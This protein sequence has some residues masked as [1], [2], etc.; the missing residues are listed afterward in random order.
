MELKA[1]RGFNDILPTETGQW[2]VV[3]ERAREVLEGFGFSEIRVPILEKTE[4]FSRSIGEETDIVE[5]EMYTFQ[6]RSGDLVTLRPEATASLA[7]A[8]IEHKMYAHDPMAKLYSIGP[9]FRHERPQKGRYRQFHQVDVE[10]FGVSHPMVDAEV[11][12]ILMHYLSVL[13][14]KGCELQIT[15]LG[16][17]TCRVPYKEDL[18]AFLRDHRSQL[19]PDC[20]RR[21]EINPLRVFD[22]KVQG[23]QE[24]MS[25]APLIGNYLCQECDEH[26]AGVKAYLETLDVPYMIN[27][28]MVRGLDY[29]TKTAFEVVAEALG[30]QNAV[31]GGGRYDRL[32]EELG[33]PNIPGIGFSIGM[34]RLLLILPEEPC[35]S[36]PSLF[37]AA[38]GEVAQREAFSL[39]YR[40][41]V[42][43]VRAM[44]GF[45]GRS[46]KAQ[47]RRANK[48]GARYVLIIGEDELRE[49]KA[50]LRDMEGRRQQ[51]IP[52]PGVFEEV[53][54]RIE[55]SL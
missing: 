34:E 31:A 33:G 17:P 55:G 15:S 48:F 7:R 8:Y 24:V 50:I 19:C 2:R 11:M 16:C 51:E 54:S 43:G 14:V 29:Y 18:K 46:L 20:R 25:E 26:F 37:I 45:E 32:I 36:G 4:L 12:A 39:S 30:A 53:I 40:L 22:C 41:N 6:D 21:M 28:R 49:G 47:M 42:A 3:E 38:L 9:M 44:M 10:V 5:K 52:L 27:P 13:G 23:C 35:P 1:I